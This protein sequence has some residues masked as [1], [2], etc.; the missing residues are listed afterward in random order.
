MK[1]S[2]ANELDTRC[3]PANHCKGNSWPWSSTR[4]MKGAAG[5]N[6]HGHRDATMILLSYRDGLRAS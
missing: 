2:W 6:R 1:V 5:D 3:R 4:L